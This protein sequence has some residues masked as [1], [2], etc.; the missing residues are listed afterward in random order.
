MLGEEPG[1]GGTA[2]YVD[3]SLE[4]LQ[5][6]ISGMTGERYI[7]VCNGRRV[8]LRCTGE[9]G[10][11]VGGVKRQADATGL[12]EDDPAFRCT[13]GGE[14]KSLM[15]EIITALEVINAQGDDVN[16]GVTSQ[17]RFG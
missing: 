16:S 1:G 14:P 17:T 12:E 10:E 11:F 4:R 5:V 6:K 9:R 8:P 15:V 3:S 13:S 7:V 2:R